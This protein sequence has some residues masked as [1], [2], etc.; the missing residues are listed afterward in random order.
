M[1]LS[2]DRTGPTVL[3][4]VLEQGREPVAAS[5]RLYNGALV[6]YDA[7][8]NVVVVADSAAQDGKAIHYTLEG[9]DNSAGAAGDK[10][11]LLM[12]RGTAIL[13]ASVIVAADRGKIA[14]AT[15]DNVLALTSTNN[16][17]VGFIGEVDSV[18][19]TVQIG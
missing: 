11:V 9:C 6:S 1:A 12:K 14:H 13:E 18:N 10:K 16:R 19:V 3:G 4:P 8:G 7:N 5:T 15:S 2:A 17:P